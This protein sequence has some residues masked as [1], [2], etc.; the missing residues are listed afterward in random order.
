MQMCIHIF[1]AKHSLLE[2]CY[3]CC[4]TGLFVL[5]KFFCVTET[6]QYI[7]GSKQTHLG[8]K[9]TSLKLCKIF[10]TKC[11][12]CLQ[13]SA[14][15]YSNSYSKLQPARSDMENFLI[16]LC[17]GY[18]YRCLVQPMLQKGWAQH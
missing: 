3:V 5:N 2:C 8:I 13:F 15:Q 12:Y 1:D 6:S 10:I 18:L 14:S 7:M 4:D 16:S 17:A 11:K 9:K